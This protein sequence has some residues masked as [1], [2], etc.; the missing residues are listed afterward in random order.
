MAPHIETLELGREPML[1]DPVGGAIAGSRNQIPDLAQWR[2]EMQVHEEA[3]LRLAA[4][5]DTRSFPPA[6]NYHNDIPIADKIARAL[7]FMVRATHT[8]IIRPE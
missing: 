1:R 4:L 2:K 7:A 3:I 6:V 8:T 5:V